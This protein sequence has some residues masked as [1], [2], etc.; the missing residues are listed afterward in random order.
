MT[1]PFAKKPPPPEEK[2]ISKK[3]RDE[4]TAIKRQIDQNED[5]SIL[6][7][8][9]SY[10]LADMESANREGRLDKR[11]DW[12]FDI[13]Q[14]KFVHAKYLK[15]EELIS[16][17]F[18]GEVEWFRTIAKDQLDLAKNLTTTSIGFLFA[19]NSGILFGSLN[20]LVSDKAGEYRGTI[21]WFLLTS[22][23]G[24]GILVGSTRKASEWLR[25][26]ALKVQKAIR[27]RPAA[28]RIKALY[29]WTRKY[30]ITRGRWLDYAY[31]GSFAWIAFYIL[32]GVLFVIIRPD[33]FPS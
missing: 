4:W 27:I 31:Y 18:A 22:V 23:I 25:E 17:N 12:T 15:A 30:S 1:D 26:W 3:I 5:A 2:S 10:F 6:I 29:K 28:P 7:A 16:K 9:A 19:I 11:Y 33:N 32:I 14:A 21:I 20:A 24:T 8:A 13:I